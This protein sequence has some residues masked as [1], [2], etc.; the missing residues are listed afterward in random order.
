MVAYHLEGEA[1]LWYQLLKD[2]GQELTLTTLKEGLYMSSVSETS[3]QCME[4]AAME[5]YLL[6]TNKDKLV[7]FRLLD[8]AHSFVY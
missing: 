3:D 7:F 1:Q 5:E 2:E 4:V 6:L 8:Y